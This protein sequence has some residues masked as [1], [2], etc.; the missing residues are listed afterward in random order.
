MRAIKP[1][2]ERDQESDRADDRHSVQE[3]LPNLHLN[4]NVII[5]YQHSTNGPDFILPQVDLPWPYHRVLCWCWKRTCQH[6]HAVY[7]YCCYIVI[8]IRGFMMKS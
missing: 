4:K 7:V 3:I 5:V 8:T 2:E 1:K 6:I